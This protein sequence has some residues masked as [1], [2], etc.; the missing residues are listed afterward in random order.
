MAEE[1]KAR[2]WNLDIKNA[3]AVAE[4]GLGLGR[5]FAKVM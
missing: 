5:A 1:V 2:G 4:G 3:C